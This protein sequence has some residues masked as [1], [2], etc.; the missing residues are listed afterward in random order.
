[1]ASIVVRRLSEAAEER[2]RQRSARHKRRLEAEVR[3]DVA[4]AEQEAAGSADA[5]EPFP[6]WSIGITRPGIDLDAV[7]EENRCSSSTPGNTASERRRGVPR[8]QE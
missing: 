1:M 3:A 6:D 8:P 2:R 5:G 4:R 7:I